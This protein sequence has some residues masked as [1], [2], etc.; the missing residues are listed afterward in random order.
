MPFP[1][2]IP[3]ES[4]DESDEEFHTRLDKA[5]EDGYVEIFTTKC[6]VSGP[7]GT[8]KSNFRALISGNE[9]P[10]GRQSTAL[11]TEA[12]QI[13]PAA[14]ITHDFEEE[15]IEFHRNKGNLKVKWLVVGGKKLFQLISKTIHN[16]E[17]GSKHSTSSL[18]SSSLD[19]GQVVSVPKRTMSAIRKEI[20]KNLKALTKCK[21]KPKC[22][23]KMKLLL[24]VDTGG[25][26]QFQ[27]IMPIFVRNS[28]MTLLVHKLN[29]TLKDRPRFDYEINGVR[30]S[31]PDELLV[32]NQE[33]LEQS[34]RTICSCSFSRNISQLSQNRIPKPHFAIIGMFKDK[35]DEQMLEEKNKA[36][37]ECIKP[38]TQSRKCVAL[39][40]SRR[41]DNPVFAIDGSE[42]GWTDNGDVIDDIH[43]HIETVTEGLGVKIPIRWFLF[44][45]LLKD[46]SKRSPFL[47]LQR[48]NEIAKEEDILMDEKDVDEALVL[49]D[50]LNLILYFPN[51]LHNVVFC[52]PEFLYNKVS[53]IIAQSFDC[54][55]ASS[56]LTRHERMEFRK[57][58]I[59][60]KSLLER[61][62]SLRSGFDEILFK[63][64]DLLI[65]LKKRCI[66]A[67]VSNDQFF[68][69]CVLALQRKED[70]SAWLHEI[71]S[72]MDD[73]LCIQPLIISFPD[74]Y[75]PRGLFC[76]SV[77]HL[78]KLSNWVVDSPRIQLERKRN[79]IE[80]EYREVTKSDYQ[81]QR[82]ASLG[83][84][85]I[86]DMVSQIEVY[87]TCDK[88]HLCEIRRAIYGAL[89]HAAES[90]S[91]SPTDVE[92]NVGFA[93]QVD[94]GVSEFHGTAVNYKQKT[95]KWSSKCIKNSSKR[96]KPLTDEEMC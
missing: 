24:I 77:A 28:S 52:S 15:M 22:L 45:D 38:F 72:H 30:Y 55:D 62:R 66:I 5:L 53:E 50:E 96:A 64:N 68:I 43:T 31:V 76:A 94:C 92:V 17:K 26:P 73:D 8:G 71:R 27:E 7:P 48:C 93:C 46:Y 69:P 58:G 37:N 89:W 47:S 82:A 29:E 10:E 18:S 20:K 54:R 65:L 56:G 35:C 32:T 34:L 83:R 33:Y 11:A 13:I 91:Y 39:M 6:G 80:F 60:S 49:F 40:P 41:V 85:V 21:R 70:N 42:Q 84:V 19:S 81:V 12:D 75:S 2:V 51:I 14:C 74:G 88:E 1:S 61:V 63:I 16:Q 86:T 95:R 9:R 87:S 4:E 78:A 25:Q 36:V 90:L 67:E 44:L 57:T 3:T 59:F 79:L 23:H